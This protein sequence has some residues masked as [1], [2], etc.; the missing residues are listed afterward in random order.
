MNGEHLQQQRL[1]D[2]FEDFLELP[3]IPSVRRGTPPGS[4][5]PAEYVA[6]APE[7]ALLDIHEEAGHSPIAVVVEKDA[8]GIIRALRVH[9]ACGSS[10]VITLTYDDDAIGTDTA[11]ADANM[12]TTS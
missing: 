12:G 6:I 1:E 9:C 3:L 5:V 11:P 4:M 2:A 7:P 8:Y 10:A